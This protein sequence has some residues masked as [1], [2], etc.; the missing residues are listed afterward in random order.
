M[1][2]STVMLAALGMAVVGRWAHNA[3]F[4][5]AYVAKGAFAFFVVALLDNGATAPV[6]QGFAWL[7]FA[8]VFLGG[9]SPITG[10]V[11]AV[12]GK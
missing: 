1:R 3:P 9:N 11:K 7:F 5:G 2:A 10:V 8:A 6:A 4:T 12:N